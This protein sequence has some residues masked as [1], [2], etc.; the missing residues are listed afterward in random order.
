MK[1]KP[2]GFVATCQCERTVGALDFTRSTQA[3]TGKI[4]GRWLQDGCTVTPRFTG[5]WEVKVE[6]C[7]CEPQR[8]QQREGQPTQAQPQKDSNQ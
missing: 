8:A 1:R 4:L 3:D 6:A 5:S 2:T 7:T